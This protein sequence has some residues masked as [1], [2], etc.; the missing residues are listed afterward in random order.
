MNNNAFGTIAA[1]VALLLG[2]MTQI[3]G[4]SMDPV[5]Q[6]SVCTATWIPPEWAGYVVLAFS[7]IALVS[8]LFRPG[9]PV[10]GLFAPSAVIVPEAKAGPGTVTPEQVA[11]R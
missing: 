5:T 6:A 2:A 7:G 8:K 1:I 9:G 11:E 4:C 3:F 10:A